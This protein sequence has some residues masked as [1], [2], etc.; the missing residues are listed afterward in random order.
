MELGVQGCCGF[1]DIRVIW[2]TQRLQI[3]HAFQ[4][5]GPAPGAGWRHCAFF[6]TSVV[7]KSFTLSATFHFFPHRRRLFDRRANS[8]VKRR[9]EKYL[10]ETGVPASF[11]GFGGGID[12]STG[13]LEWRE[14][15]R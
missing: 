6:G 5:L 3:S 12:P 1:A 8:P 11:K 7:F 13:Q 14:R 15:C 10:R 9:G 2:I 4:E